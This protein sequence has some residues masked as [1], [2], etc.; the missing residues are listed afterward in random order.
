MPPRH[1]RAAPAPRPSRACGA[2][3]CVERDL[4]VAPE[5]PVV[6]AGSSAAASHTIVSAPCSGVRSSGRMTRSN[7]G[8]E[9]LM[10]G[11][12]AQP[13]C[14]ECTTTPLPASSSA[15]ALGE[16]DLCSLAARIGRRPV[17][18]A[19]RDCR[20]S[21]SRPRRYMP[22]DETKITRA[23]ALAPGVRAAG[24]SAGAARARWSRTSARGPRPVSR[25]SAGR[26]PALWTSTCTGSP[27]ASSRSAQ[28]CTELRREMSTSSQR[29]SSF[30]RVVCNPAARL[31]PAPGIAHEHAQ[32]GAEP[33]QPCARRQAEP[34]A[35]A[36]DEADAPGQ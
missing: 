1:S 22:P 21:T 7:P 28:A 15:P 19:R 33:R 20:S 25:R 34:R 23:G 14:I 35:G 4:A 27:A 5:A 24:A 11:V 3:R 2:R 10:P 31:L 29:T 36:G 8:S 12:S 16:H 30:P 26:T 32:R 6:R 17:E 13:G 9:P 18:L